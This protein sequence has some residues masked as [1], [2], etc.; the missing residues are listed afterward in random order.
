MISYCRVF[1][2]ASFVLL[3]SFNISLRSWV[4][5][6]HVPARALKAE[7]GKNYLVVV[8][9]RAILCG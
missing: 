3:L 4:L 8:G 5:C 6:S 9:A 7:R 2:L 1:L